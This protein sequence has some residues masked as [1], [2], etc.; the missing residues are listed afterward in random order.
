MWHHLLNGLVYILALCQYT[1]FD[2]T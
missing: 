2:Y 1:S